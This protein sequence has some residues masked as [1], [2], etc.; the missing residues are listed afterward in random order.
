MIAIKTEIY[1][2]RGKHHFKESSFITLVAAWDTRV[3]NT[4]DGV[5]FPTC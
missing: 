1:V 2:E 3:S 5:V 4:S